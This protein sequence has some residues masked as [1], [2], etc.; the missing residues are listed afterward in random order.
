[1]VDMKT[2]FDVTR[3]QKDFPI[4]Q[5]EGSSVYLDSAATSLT[6]EPVLEAMNEYYRTYRA[7]I[8]RG[9]YREAERASKEYEDARA[10]VA[11]FI[12]AESD[13]VV[14]TAG[15]TH[16][17]NMLMYAFEHTDIFQEGDEIVTTIMEH[18][19]VLLPLQA[20][21][22]RKKLDLRYIELGEHFTLDYEQ[23]E[24][25]ITNKTKLVA[26]T[27]ASNVL[28]TINN[29]TRVARRAHE[30]GA[31]VV[32]DATAAMGH[33][34]VDV[35]LLDADFLFF[36]GHKMC[37]PT[38]VGVLFGKKSELEKLEPSFLGGGIIEDVTRTDFVAGEHPWSFEAGTPNIAGVIGLKTAVKYVERIGLENT[39]A[40]CREI[41]AYA[42]EALKKIEGMTL[43]SAEPAY[44]IGI[45]SFAL[46]SVH[47]HDMAEM[48]GKSGVAVRAGHHCAV[49]LHT[50]L[51]VPATT[52]ASVYLYTTEQDIDALIESIKNAKRIFEK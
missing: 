46:D 33:M 3:I 52:R 39:Q 20:L 48:L 2:F 51:C 18:N 6:P 16:A 21:V 9:L 5:K 41:L 36:S 14:F 29:V 47:P 50:D 24:K 13:E 38:G 12:G 11:Q 45:V 25:C 1:M 40:H 37:G 31:L 49:V 23:A 8:H 19:A 22:K 44:N 35:K 27:L 34:P 7:N 26:L 28:G 17:S 10:V 30:V 42:Q 43:Y 32:V 15:A 4:L